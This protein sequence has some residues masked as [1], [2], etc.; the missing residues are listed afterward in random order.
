MTDLDDIRKRDAAM[1]PEWR[2][3]R[4][5][6]P[7]DL[8]Y[9]VQ[10][11]R[12]LLAE[13]DRLTAELD[14]IRSAL[15]PLAKTAETLCAFLEDCPLEELP[16]ADGDKLCIELYGLHTLAIEADGVLNKYRRT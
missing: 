10:D 16:G 8:A 11:R 9:A 3:L 14:E 7:E 2:K 1:H 12:A 6:G 13:V 15:V 5:K 4:L